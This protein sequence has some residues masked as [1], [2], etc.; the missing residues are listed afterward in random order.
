MH[1]NVFG[2]QGV[3]AGEPSIAESCMCVR[4]YIVYYNYSLNYITKAQLLV[5][6]FL[7]TKSTA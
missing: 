2:G 7:R 3:Q 1:Q 6:P 4:K 5:A